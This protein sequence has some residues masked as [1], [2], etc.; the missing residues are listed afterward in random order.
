[1]G[2]FE[3]VVQMVDDFPGEHVGIRKIIGSLQ[4][5]VFE[6]EDGEGAILMIER[7]SMSPFVP[8]KYY[9]SEP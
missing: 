7:P 3:N 4:A 8:F 6:P 5:F 1:M 9:V 2:S